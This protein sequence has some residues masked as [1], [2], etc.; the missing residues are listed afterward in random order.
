MLSW[1]LIV[2]WSICGTHLDGNFCWI[3]ATVLHKLVHR[4]KRLKVGIFAIF[5]D[6]LK[7]IKDDNVNM[8][9]SVTCTK[10]V[11]L[12]M[13]PVLQNSNDNLAKMMTGGLLVVVETSDPILL[14]RTPE[15]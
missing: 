12:S 3:D 13:W 9:F 5:Q 6:D 11:E 2:C 1:V 10:L 4:S 15:L 14:Q 8:L 7:F